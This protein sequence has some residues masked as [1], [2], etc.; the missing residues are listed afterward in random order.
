M[1]DEE[2]DILASGDPVQIQEMLGKLK[3]D[4]SEDMWKNTMKPALEIL[5]LTS[6]IEEEPMNDFVLRPGKPVLK[7]NKNDLLIGGTKLEGELGGDINNRNE[8]LN[9]VVNEGNT[10]V[11][12][13][14]DVPLL[15]EGTIKF[16]GNNES[17]NVD[18]DRIIKQLS[19]GKY[20]TIEKII[21]N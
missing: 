3:T 19:T 21:T 6:E 16:E 13:G 18:I 20:T 7:F 12:A 14:A 9:N 2:L 11:T 10:S 5:G 4:L 17:A 1:S 8:T 15:V